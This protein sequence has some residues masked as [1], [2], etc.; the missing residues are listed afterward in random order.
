MSL[1]YQTTNTGADVE[2][3]P[4]PGEVATLLL[5]DRVGHHDGTLSGPEQTGA[6]TE[7]GTGEDVEP[8]DICM[9]GDEKTN[10]VNAVPDSTKGE[11]NPNAHTVDDSSGEETHH[12]EGT[13]QSDVLLLLESGSIKI[14][15]SGGSE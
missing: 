6:D 4:E 11:G 14:T 1:S 15:K 13:V 3:T 9:F 10:G 2:D 8:G 5:L 12:R 7:E